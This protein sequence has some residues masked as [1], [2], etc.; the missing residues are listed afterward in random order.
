MK[1][2]GRAID[3]N[4]LYNGNANVKTDVG[5]RAAN[6]HTENIPELRDV[7]ISDVTITRATHSG[8]ILGL[9]EKPVQDITLNN[10][11]I[12]ADDGLLIEDAKNIQFNNVTL[13][14]HVG[15]P[16]TTDNAEVISSQP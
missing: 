10:V 1:N 15:P 6:G 2:V 16:I 4:M 13:N 12:E 7:V 3:I 8:R 9:P 14:I 11:K 5:S